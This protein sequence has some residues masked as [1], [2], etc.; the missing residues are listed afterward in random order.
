MKSAPAAR[1][2]QIGGMRRLTRSPA[3]TAMALV[4]TSARAE[5]ANT[6]QREAPPL[7][8]ERVASWVLSPISARKMAANVE[9]KSFQSTRAGW[10]AAAACNSSGPHRGPGHAAAALAASA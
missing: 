2:V 1:L 3:A 4:S 7:A 5:A 8:A 10:H 6:T 9:K